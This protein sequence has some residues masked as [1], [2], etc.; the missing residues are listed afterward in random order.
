MRMS[1]RRPPPSSLNERQQSWEAEH[2][3]QISISAVYWCNRNG[4]LALSSLSLCY[5]CQPICINTDT[6]SLCALWRKHTSDVWRF[7]ADRSQSDVNWWRKLGITRGKV[8][9]LPRLKLPFA[10]LCFLFYEK[11]GILAMA[12][13]QT[14][15]NNSKILI[16]TY[17]IEHSTLWSFI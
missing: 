12:A 17:K 10:S 11:N 8:S 4:A 13:P 3:A 14:D 15:G 1:K 5:G 16:F 7:R 2:Q 6:R 9:W